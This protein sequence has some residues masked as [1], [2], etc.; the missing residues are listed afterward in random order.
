VIVLEGY[1]SKLLLLLDQYR[2]WLPVGFFIAGFIFD[3]LTLTRVDDPLVVFQ[4]ALCL[5]L[6][7]V[8]V[9]VELKEDAGV[10]YV[11]PKLLTRVWPYREEL[12]HFVLGT[13]LNSYTIF[14]FKSSSALTSFL[15]IALLVV[16]LV[17]NEF[18]RFGHTRARVHLIFF[19]VCLISYFLVLVPV[20][21]G[22][23]GLSTFTIANIIAFICF[24][25]FQRVLKMSRRLVLTPLVAAQ[26]VF[27]FLYF[28]RVIPP[29]PLSVKYMGIYHQIQKSG[30]AYE[31]QYTRSRWLFWQN[32]D[33]SYYARPGDVIYCFVQVFSPSGF[34]DQLQV[35]WLYRDSKRGWVSSDAIPLTIVGGREDGYRGMT[36]KQNYTHGDW[37]VVVETRDGREV[38][39]LGFEV[40]PDASTEPRVTRT[41]IR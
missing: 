7:A 12:L 16:L 11:P 14:Y 36:Y 18:R 20:L 13:L 32:G 21:L 30:G 5:L 29:V 9:A 6:V 23:L 40:L 24:Y 3:A 10:V 19:G 41:V 2:Q 38:G 4:Q 26:I 28:A 1:K 39:R 34:K 25:C 31:L 37:R 17:V 35:R 27:I 22:F 33:Q 8:L 15:F